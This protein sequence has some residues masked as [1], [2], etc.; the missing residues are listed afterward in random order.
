MFWIILIPI[1]I[2][3]FV[4]FIYGGIKQKK[5]DYVEPKFNYLP[6]EKTDLNK[7]ET[8]L[9]QL[10]NAHRKSIGLNELKAEV[11]ASQVCREAIIEDLKLA[12]AP[13]HDK[14]EQRK[15]ACKAF[16]AKEIIA[17]NMSEPKSVLAGYLRSKD[18]RSVIESKTV[19]HI[20][21]SY[22]NRINYCILTQYK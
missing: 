7:Q 16:D 10:I 12:E 1:A 8:E 22:I 2:V 15:L 4:I 19:T 11:L 3:G 6:I 13:S 21:L 9:L 14:W 17:P 18:H 5:P 20:G